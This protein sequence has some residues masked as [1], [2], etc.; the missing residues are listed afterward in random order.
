MIRSGWWSFSTPWPSGCEA[1]GRSGWDPGGSGR[2]SSELYPN[3]ASG[4]ANRFGALFGTPSQAVQR[5]L[6]RHGTLLRPG[7]QQ[8]AELRM[9]REQLVDQIVFLFQRRQLEGRHAVDG[10]DDRLLLAQAA[11]MAQPALG[12]RQWDDLHGVR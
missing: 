10:D 1:D 3:C 6:R 5:F 11:V 7:F 8:G 4:D 9:F 2:D 12:F